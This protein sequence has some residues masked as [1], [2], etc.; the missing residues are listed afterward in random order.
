MMCEFCEGDVVTSIYERKDKNECCSVN[1]VYDSDGFY[2]NCYHDSNGWDAAIMDIF[3]R[4]YFC[5]MCGRKL[6]ERGK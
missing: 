1:I 3:P 5:P 4:I 2:L 6:E